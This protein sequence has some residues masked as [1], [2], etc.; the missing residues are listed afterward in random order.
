MHPGTARRRGPL[1]FVPSPRVLLP[2]IWEWWLYFSSVHI[3]SPSTC[4]KYQYHSYSYRWQAR[5][6]RVAKSSPSSPLTRGVYQS[7]Q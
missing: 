4:D 7:Q 5:S 2:G 3:F 6:G 1:F